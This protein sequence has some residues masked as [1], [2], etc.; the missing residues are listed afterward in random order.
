MNISSTVLPG[1][2]RR[3]ITWGGGLAVGLGLIG[4][5]LVFAS[6]WPTFDHSPYDANTMILGAGVCL[7]S[8]SYA[9]GRIAVAAATEDGRRPVSPPTAKPY[10]VAGVSLLIAIICLLIVIR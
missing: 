9:F 3:R 5:P 1:S 4:L 6:V 7:S 10:V 2:R 8:L